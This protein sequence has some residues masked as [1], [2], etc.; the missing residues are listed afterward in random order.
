M[1]VPKEEERVENLFEEIAAENF[2]NL[3][4]EM[5]FQ[6]QKVQR[7]LGITYAQNVHIESYHNQILKSQRQRENLKTARGNQLATYKEIT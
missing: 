1:K 7:S 4:K 6:I 2:R 5:D 3:V